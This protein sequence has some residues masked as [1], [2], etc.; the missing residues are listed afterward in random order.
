MESCIRISLSEST[1]RYG[2]TTR[3]A[4]RFGG[5]HSH[6]PEP[7]TL[8]AGRGPGHRSGW[9]CF[10]LRRFGCLS[11][12]PLMTCRKLSPEMVCLQLKKH[13]TACRIYKDES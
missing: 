1:S 12:P 13:V 2:L 11:E 3:G 5:S 9:L 8:Q 7:V 10:S 4:T 6:R